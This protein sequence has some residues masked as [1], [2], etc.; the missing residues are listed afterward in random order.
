LEDKFYQL[1][2]IKA[3]MDGIAILNPREELVFL[4]EA[5]A[6]INVCRS[7]EELLGERLETFYDERE[8]KR[9]RGGILPAV[10][11]VGRWRGEA[12]AKR[13]DGTTY[14]QELSLAR[15]EDGGLVCVIRDI[16]KRK[17]SEA[18]LAEARDMALEAAR[19]KAEFLANMSHE[20]RTPM[21]GVVGMTG[22]LLDTELDPLQREFAESIKSSADALLKVIDDILDFSK[23]EAGKLRFENLEFDPRATVESVVEVVAERAQA[24]GIELVSFVEPG[25]PARLCGDASRLRQVLLN[26]LSNAVKFTD[27]G[28]VFVRVTVEG[29]TPSHVTARFVVRDTGIGISRAG[30]QQL[31]QPFT[32]A[33]GSTTRKYGGTGLGLVISKHIVELM[34]GEIGVESAEGAGATFWFTARFEKQPERA[35]TPTNSAEGVEEEALEGLRVLVVDAYQTRREILRRHA[36]AW[37]MLDGG[38]AS[39]AEAIAILRRE[40][41]AGAPYDLA[42]LDARL[43]ETGATDSAMDLVRAIKAEPAISATRLVL[44]IPLGLRGAAPSKLRAA[45]VAAWLTKPVKHSQLLNSLLTAIAPEG[46]TR[47]GSR[48]TD[49]RPPAPRVNAPPHRDANGREDEGAR[50]LVVEDNPVNRQVALHQLRRF[51]HAVEAVTNGREALEA[52]ARADY[53]LIL[54]DCQMPEMDGYETTA[55]IRRREGGQRHTPI[56]AMTAHTFE[57]DR[58]RC[59][60]AGMDDYLAKPVE[61]AV[62]QNVLAHWLGA[63]ARPSEKTVQG[64]SAV[65]CTLLEQIMKASVLSAFREGLAEDDPDPVVELLKLFCR[66]TESALATL[67]DALGRGDMLTVERTA[68]SLKGGSEVLGLQKLAALSAEMEEQARC[69]SPTG[70]EVIAGQIESEL[71]LV[72]RALENEQARGSQEVP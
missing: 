15:L 45:G 48:G 69:D 6:R 46:T 32:Q 13:C 54:M 5:Y 52:L 40:A 49:G 63:S 65:P 11:R 33:D 71:Q 64:A 68:H 41:A 2:A 12:L 39:G 70:L 27:Q 22:L 35:A 18:E 26:L 44:L 34:G 38:A 30:Q 58:E 8:H 37:G 19:L 59:L 1:A 43:P 62:L 36:A 21:N 31:F 20:I 17:E 9:L 57:G 67:E 53:D 60:A 24:K 23:I 3:S 14:T 4:N 66:N 10:E 61:P 16:T 50:V 55:R 28:E 51:G 47:A 7:A 56:I 29:E 25:V 72:R 42:I